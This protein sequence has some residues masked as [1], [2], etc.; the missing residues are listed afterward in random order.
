MGEPRRCHAA[1]C[2]AAPQAETDPASENA[3]L[4]CSAR[5][6]PPTANTCSENPK[7]PTRYQTLRKVSREGWGP[8][9]RFAFLVVV[10]AVCSSTVLGTAMVALSALLM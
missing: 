8:T 5:R 3:R 10:V 2:F 7:D 4:E 1:V 6:D 9:F